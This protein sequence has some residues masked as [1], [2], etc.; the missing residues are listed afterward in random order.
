LIALP[1]P[2][3]LC[4]DDDDQLEQ[5]DD[6]VLDKTNCSQISSPYQTASDTLRL[7]D[8][9]LE[10]SDSDIANVELLPNGRVKCNHTCKDKKK[11]GKETFLANLYHT[12]IVSIF[13]LLIYPNYFQ[14]C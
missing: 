13:A 11:Y 3:A 2:L 9:T 10:N 8:L 12:A 14:M 7:R 5:K 1:P 4:L 6:S